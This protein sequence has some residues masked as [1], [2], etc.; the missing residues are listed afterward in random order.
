MVWR[1]D[2]G[3]IRVGCGVV[4]WG[5][6]GGWGGWWWSRLEWSGVGMG[7][8]GMEE[9]WVKCRVGWVGWDWG[10]VGEVG[11]GEGVG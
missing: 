9:G 6:V 11:L 4:W 7:Q 8:D 3:L 2:W 1:G 10:E 5:L